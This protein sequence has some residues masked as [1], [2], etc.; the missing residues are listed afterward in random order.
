[1][2]EAI[3]VTGIAWC[4]AKAGATTTATTAAVAAA[5]ARGAFEGIRGKN[6]APFFYPRPFS[7]TELL[8]ALNR[9]AHA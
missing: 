4:V 8:H 2:G 9:D 6:K 3:L 1:M 5:V 7:T